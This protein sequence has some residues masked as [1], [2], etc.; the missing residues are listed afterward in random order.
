[1]EMINNKYL[2]KTAPVVPPMLK[3]SVVHEMQQNV[4]RLHD[5]N[6]AISSCIN[7]ETVYQKQNRKRHAS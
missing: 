1:M 2:N 3:V 4:I 7:D 6:T 5:V